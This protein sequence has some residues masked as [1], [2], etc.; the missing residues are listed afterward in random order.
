MAAHVDKAGI[1]IDCNP[2][3]YIAPEDV[4]ADD[5]VELVARIA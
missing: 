2:G 1:R 3:G 5:N 4:W